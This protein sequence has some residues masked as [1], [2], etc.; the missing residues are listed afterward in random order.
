[1]KAHSDAHPFFLYLAFSNPHDPRIAA[2]K[3][4]DA[5]DERQIPLPANFRPVHPFDN[6]EMTVRD[7]TLLPWPRTE[8]AIRRTLHDYYATITG[9]DFHIGRLLRALHDL[10]QLDNTIVIFTADQGIAVGS[11]GLLGKQS[12]YDAA[13]KVPL[14]F[15]GPGIRPGSSDALV[16]LLDLYPTVCGLV[17]ADVP[18]GL[19]GR[20]FQGVLDGTSTAARSTLLLSYRDVQRAVRD[21]RWKLIRYPQVDITQLFDLENDPDEMRNLAADPQH[22]L[23]VADLLARLRSVQA[24]FGDDLPLTVPNP[25]PARWTPPHR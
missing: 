14:V 18:A 20:S 15:A 13:M 3:Y 4:R 11:H 8:P 5:Y 1:M 17:G 10:G 21:E 16:Y 23:R 24:Q 25:K 7:E 2:R 6:G 22:A 19:D 9:L 12:L